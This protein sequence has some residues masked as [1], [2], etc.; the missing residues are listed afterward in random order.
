MSA[1]SAGGEQSEGAND[2]EDDSSRHVAYPHHPD[3]RL[4][5]NKRD[6]CAADCRALIHDQKSFL[7]AQF[8]GPLCSRT[9]YGGRSI[10]HIILS[11][12][13]TA[14]QFEKRHGTGLVKSRCRVTPPKIHSLSLVR[15]YAPATI[16]LLP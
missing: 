2:Q 6:Y 14:N 9:S 8:R 1:K 16:I 3:D 11:L 5:C 10:F 15:P 12:G 7:R 13:I 4:A